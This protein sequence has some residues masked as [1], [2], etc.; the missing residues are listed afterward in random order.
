[1]CSHS[2]YVTL[3]PY[4]QRAKDLEEEMEKT[5]HSLQGQVRVTAVHTVRA[6]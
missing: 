5:V 4:R 6:L 3:V 1:M 2:L